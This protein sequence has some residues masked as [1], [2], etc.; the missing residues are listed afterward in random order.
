M[1]KFI[2]NIILFLLPVLF[3]TVLYELF[4]RQ[5]PTTYEFKKLLMENNQDS[6]Q[7]VIFGTSHV[8]SGINPKSLNLFTVNM[9][10]NSQSL[11]YDV[12]LLEKYL[13]RLP[14]LKRVIFEIN[15]FSF[16]YDFDNSPDNWRS[17]FYEKYWGIK[18]Q[19]K[20]LDYF[21]GLL[22]KHYPLNKLLALVES[23]FDNRK[24]YITKGWS[25]Y[26]GLHSPMSNLIAT[27]RYKKLK[28][29][30]MNEKVLNMN[31]CLI[32]DILKILH[33]KKIY[34]VFIQTPLT[35]YL[36]NSIDQEVKKINDKIIQNLQKNN[37]FSYLNYS[38]DKRFSDTLFS[39]VDHLD[40]RGASVFSDI[41][42]QDLEKCNYKS[43]QTSK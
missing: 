36:N 31:M 28:N 29:D 18:P 3:L 33:S 38:C 22:I 37:S 34:V 24:T 6:I 41:L 9:A 12:K 10:N 30:Y 13:D 8:F 7:Q 27:N 15:F 40:Y 26:N 42:S 19:T 2:S 23:S 14:K 21:D 35:H 32:E 1:N 16:F 11:Y 39:D 20:K 5:L 25:L 43:R 4:L 17:L